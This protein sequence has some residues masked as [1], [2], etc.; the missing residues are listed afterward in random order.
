[1]KINNFFLNKGQKN[2]VQL[3]KLKNKKNI[4]SH[5]KSL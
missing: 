4:I 3:K 1:M 2:Y 5:A